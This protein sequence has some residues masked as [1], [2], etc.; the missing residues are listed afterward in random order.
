MGDNTACYAASAFRSMDVQTLRCL[1]A[2]QVSLQHPRA[3][4]VSPPD[5]IAILQMLAKLV[6]ASNILEIGVFTGPA[7]CMPVN[8]HLQR[9]SPQLGS[10]A[11]VLECGDATAHLHEMS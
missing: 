11:A 10:T 6:G 5:S 9:M 8:R 7:A 4:M 1:A 3:G 2:A